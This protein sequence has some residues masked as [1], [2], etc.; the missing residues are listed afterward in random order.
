MQTIQLFLEQMETIFKIILN[1]FYE[2]SELWQT[3]NFGTPQDQCFDFTLG[4][5]KIDKC[6]DFKYL[7]VILVEIGTS[8]KKRNIMLRA[9]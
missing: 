1:M 7:G 9:S 2:C 5:H 6:T 3:I 8:T 4:G